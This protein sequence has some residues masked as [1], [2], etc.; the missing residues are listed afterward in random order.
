M[1][2]EMEG[3]VTDNRRASQGVRRPG[4]TIGHGGPGVSYMAWIRIGTRGA[5]AS[6]TRRSVSKR[7]RGSEGQSLVELA[8]ILPILLLLGLIAVDF[9][10]IYLGW[11]NLQNMTRIAANF[12]ANNPEAWLTNTTKNLT[13]RDQ[14]RNQILE[15]AQATN[16]AL[17]PAAPPPPVFTDSD[18]DGNKN[19]IGDKVEVALTCRFSVIT[20][21]ISSIIGGQVNV[22]ATSIFPVKSAITETSSGGGGGCLAPSPAINA[23][24]QTGAAP[25]TVDFTDSS[26]GGAGTSWLWDFGDTQSSTLRDPH[27]HIYTAAGNYTVTLSVT[28]TC[29]T[30][31]TNPGI[32]ITVT[33]ANPPSGCVVPNFNGV[34]RNSAQAIWGLPK[35]PNAG[36]T[37]TILDGPGHANGNYIIRSQNIVA[38]TTVPC[39]SV[40]TVNS[41]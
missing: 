17:N 11:V 13:I 3:A 31:T 10:R 6:R 2:G 16:C 37:T 35:P 27:N 9:G 25:L 38:S 40:I 24:P 22:S 26:G 19:G 30:F 41:N 34:R 15:D 20:P 7:G 23:N 39:N 4:G 21:V 29:G 12:A 8:I 18:G 5:D 36:F 14:Y 1:Q 28:N 33:P 32:V